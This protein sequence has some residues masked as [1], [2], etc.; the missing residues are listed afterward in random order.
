V[1]RISEIQCGGRETLDM[2]GLPWLQEVLRGG[3]TKGGIYL[4]SGEPGIG[5]TTLAVQILADLLLS[6]YLQQPVPPNTLFA[7]ELD[8]T[9]RIR[10]PDPNYLAELA[11]ILVRVHSGTIQRIYLSVEA[12]HDMKAHLTEQEKAAQ[13]EGAG[14][15]ANIEMIGVRDL[16]C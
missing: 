5:K 1:P 7:G 16:V 9:S 2:L 13:T 6:S 12:E 10:R 4:P 15:L 14:G 8:L 11:Q 3:L